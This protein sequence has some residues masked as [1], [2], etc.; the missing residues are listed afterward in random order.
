[1]DNQISSITDKQTM[2]DS[3]EVRKAR[4]VTWVGF[5]VNAALGVV[6]I[7]AGVFG[8]SQAMIADGI[9]SFSDF[10]SD[11]IVIIFVGISH[12]NAD[13]TYQYGHGK[14]ETLATVILAVMLG[15]VAILFF[16]EGGER[17]WNAF[18]GQILPSPTW[19]ALG[20][21]IGSIVV[22]EMLYRYTR[23]VGEQIKSSAVIANAWHHRSD[24]FSS[25]ATLVGIAG[26]MF[27]GPGFRVLDP[28]AAMAVS[29]F[30]FIVA[31]EIGKPA[32]LE[33]LEV[34]LPED[35][36]KEIW[37]IISTTPGV[38][39]FH[40]FASRRNGKRMLVD[41]HI[42]VDPDITVINAHKIASEVEKNIRAKYGDDTSVN[43]H[44]E[45]YA[46]QQV[47]IY[48]RCK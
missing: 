38:R 34:S 10:V 45:P 13:A 19:L 32:I 44:I 2:S 16:V 43:I 21:A 42:K 23:R 33:L 22:K 40:H 20:M 3:E 24:A 17:T 37:K 8:R 29:V 15:I 31:I 6:K 48:G 36:T 18:N 41:F 35:V 46:G 12:K 26:A 4:H 14:Y 5:W 30:I 27:L 9:H 28:L 25:V 1:M 47:D 7:L 39:A 11:I